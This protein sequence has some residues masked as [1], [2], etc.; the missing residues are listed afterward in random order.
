MNPK[1]DENAPLQPGSIPE[2]GNHSPD[3]TSNNNTVDSEVEQ[4]PFEPEPLGPPPIQEQTIDITKPAGAGVPEAY[5]EQMPPNSLLRDLTNRVSGNN[6]RKTGK[7]SFLVTT[8]SLVIA[9]VIVFGGIYVLISVLNVF[10]KKAEIE[11]PIRTP[12]NTAANTKP[13]ADLQNPAAAKKT[14]TAE[15]WGNDPE[16]KSVQRGFPQTNPEEAGEDLMPDIEKPLPGKGA[17]PN[18]SETFQ[19]PSDSPF[20]PDDLALPKEMIDGE[21]LP[22]NGTPE[23][24]TD[25]GEAP[26]SFDPN[27]TSVINQ[28]RPVAPQEDPEFQ[29]RRQ[30]LREEELKFEPV[31]LKVQHTIT[32][33]FPPEQNTP[34]QKIRLDVPVIHE[35]HVLALTPQEIESLRQLAL[36]TRDYQKRL[37]DLQEEGVEIL[38]IWNEIQRVGSPEAILLPDSP[39]LID[40]Q[41]S[42]RVTGQSS[43][44][45]GKEPETPQK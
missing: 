9:A 17:E 8:I 42:T 33:L 20:L 7:H 41:G 15:L 4:G 31:D 14:R 39:S 19:E 1:T 13:K 12:E 40:N 36:R 11:I 38:K 21:V 16:P 44:L 43:P 6:K 5:T 32:A 35:S 25:I 22:T 37:Q 45:S 27:N 24:T 28:A 29:N 30:K 26:P 3:E 23:V 2:T 18:T 34:P 10:T